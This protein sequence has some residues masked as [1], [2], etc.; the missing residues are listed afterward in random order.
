MFWVIAILLALILV[1]LMASDKAAAGAVKKVVWIALLSALVLALAFATFLFF[2]WFHWGPAKEDW[3]QTG[4]LLFLLTIVGFFCWLDRARLIAAYRRNRRQAVMKAITVV[5]IVALC[6]TVGY[7]IKVLLE[8]FEVSGWWLI[9][10]WLAASGTLLLTRTAASPRE[11]R[12]VWF[13]PADVPDPWSV[14][15][16]ARLESESQEEAIWARDL[17]GWS[18]L[19][20][21]EQVARQARRAGRLAATEARLAVLERLANE[22]SA[23]AAAREGSWTLRAAFWWGVAFGLVGLLPLLWRYGFDWAMTLR[24]VRGREWLAGGVTVGIA[25]VALG[26][27]GSV[28]EELTKFARDRKARQEQRGA[29]G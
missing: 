11:W 12:E 25:F 17:D 6:G 16:E 10:G 26:I 1:A 18:E 4:S 15:H 28:V 23:K 3:W 27:V 7:T 22:A 13:G 5:G 20:L 29:N 19:P 9:G 21:D 24:F 2:L 8:A 14:V